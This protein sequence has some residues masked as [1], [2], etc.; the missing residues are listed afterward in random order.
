MHAYVACFSM[1]TLFVCLCI[2]ITCVFFTF[3]KKEMMWWWIWFTIPSGKS[4][5][6]TYKDKEGDQKKQGRKEGRKMCLPSS[7][8]KF[9]CCLV[10]LVVLLVIV[11]GKGWIHHAVHTCIAGHSLVGKCNAARTSFAPP[12]TSFGAPPPF[13][14]IPTFSMRKI[15]P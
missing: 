3:K 10:L 4:K 5:P 9:G 11:L 13:S 15:S 14:S 8:C 12:P 1:W 2:P 7:L 6:T